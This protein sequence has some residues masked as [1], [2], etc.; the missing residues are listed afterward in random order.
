VCKE[1]DN[2]ASFFGCKKYEPPVR[3]TCGDA[4]PRDPLVDPFFDKFIDVQ[5]GRIFVDVLKEGEEVFCT[6]KLR[7]SKC[8][9]R[10][11]EN[12]S[13]VHD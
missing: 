2:V 10:L 1:G 4:A 5:N 8:N 11:E 13:I 3:A 7:K 9:G 12:L 6:E